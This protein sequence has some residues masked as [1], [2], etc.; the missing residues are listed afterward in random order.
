[1]K[2]ERISGALAMSLPDVWADI[3]KE[4]KEQ[5]EEELH[6][7]LKRLEECEAEISQKN[8]EIQQLRAQLAQL[9][10]TEL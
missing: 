3:A 7:K 1:V 5:E 8:I 2:P 6:Q 9:N 10:Q 4:K